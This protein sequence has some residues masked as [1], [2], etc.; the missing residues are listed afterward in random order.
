MI[1]PTKEQDIIVE[2]I[3]KHNKVKVSAR[4]GAAKT[5]TLVLAAQA[6]RVPSLYIAYNKHMAEEARNKFP[7]HVEVRTAHSYAY[8]S[9]AD[10]IKHKLVRIPG[11]GGKYNNV[12]GTGSEVARYFK[13]APFVVND[14]KSV[15]SAAMGYAVRSTVANFEYSGDYEIKE[16]HVSFREAEK[17]FKISGF[18][19]KEYAHRVL[20]YA[21][22]LWDLRIDPK[23]DVMITHDTYL[24][25]WQL[26]K[27][28]LDGYEII[29]VDEFQDMNGCLL[30][31]IL[32]HPGKV[33]GVGDDHQSIYG[34]RG[35]LNAM[36]ICD[37]PE[38]SLS[39]SFRFGQ[40]V[41]EVAKD[42]LLDNSGNRTIQFDGNENLTTKIVDKMEEDQ[43][44]MIFRTNSLLIETALD[45]ILQGKEVNMSIDV[46]DFKS[47]MSSA[48][49]L[50]KGEMKNVKHQSFVPYVSWGELMDEVE[51]SKDQ[52]VKR[53]VKFI[54]DGRYEEIM[55]ALSSYKK[56]DN[57]D[58][59]LITGHKSKGLE[60]ENVVLAEDFLPHEVDEKGNWIGFAGQEQNLLYVAATR[61]KNVLQL[62]SAIHGVKR[63]TLSNVNVFHLTPGFE[64][65]IVRDLLNSSDHAVE[66]QEQMDLMS[67]FD[68]EYENSHNVDGSL[69]LLSVFGG[70]YAGT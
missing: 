37:W 5:T 51:A 38:Y 20:K 28:S 26:S 13:L 54:N 61:A 50:R 9:H 65:N 8:R 16:K 12:C 59:F 42:I 2:A 44:T 7:E 33:V 52:E 35:S 43:Y 21:R 63:Y 31:V 41:A 62:N 47:M 15:T 45:L 25:L 57:P 36:Q 4:A 17:V 34:W 6:Y 11:V 46:S 48:N 53:I 19:K 64:S 49:A 30:E 1:T 69:R 40:E 68:D 10:S 14:Q 29:Y 56:S 27:P 58:I 24:K 23:S 22:Q 55:N 3:G 70:N 60:F 66:A 18:N 32:N 67:P 39:K